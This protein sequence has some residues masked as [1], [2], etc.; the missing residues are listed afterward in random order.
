MDLR[1]CLRITNRAQIFVIRSNGHTGAEAQGHL[2]FIP[3][4]NLEGWK[5]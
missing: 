5:F 1:L 4:V 3:L 2:V